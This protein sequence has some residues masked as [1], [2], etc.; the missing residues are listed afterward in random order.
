MI[1]ITITESQVIA[2][3]RY[4]VPDK[5]TTFVIYNQHNNSGN[6]LSTK[7]YRTLSCFHFSS[8]FKEA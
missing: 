6:F 7:G 8:R 2:S 5:V 1:I 3:I 4:F